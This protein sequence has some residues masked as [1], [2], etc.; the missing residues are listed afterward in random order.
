ME[1]TGCLLFF[2]LWGWP[3]RLKWPVGGLGKLLLLLFWALKVSSNHLIGTKKFDSRQ[4]EGC[5]DGMKWD[6][7]PQLIAWKGSARRKQ[8]VLRGARQTGNTYILQK[9]RENE[10][11]DVV[12]CNFEEDAPLDRLFAQSLDPDKIISNLSLHSKKTFYRSV[13]WLFLMRYNSLTMRWTVWNISW[14]NLLST[15]LLLRVLFLVW[16]CLRQNPLPWV[17]SIF[18]TFC[19]WVSTNSWMVPSGS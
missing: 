5:L 11:D 18:W 3:V 12:Y 19:P 9:F 8:L 13:T 2:F 6:V 10:F 15:I 16:S 14:R 17:R 4:K 1:N 7:Y